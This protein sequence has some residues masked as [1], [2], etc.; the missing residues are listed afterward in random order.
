MI[1]SKWRLT[2]FRTGIRRNSEKLL[3]PVLLESLR[4]WR[5]NG[6]GLSRASDA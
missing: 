3:P 4:I 1:G 5:S 6:Y 2:W